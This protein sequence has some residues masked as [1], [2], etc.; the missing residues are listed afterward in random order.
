MRL[1]S[2]SYPVRSVAL[3]SKG[4]RR[5]DDHGR[6]VFAGP[7]GCPDI[8]GIKTQSRRPLPRTLRPIGCPDIKGIKTRA[9][10]TSPAKAVRS[11]ALISKGLRHIPDLL[12]GNANRPIGCPDIKGIKT[13][14]FRSCMT[15]PRP[16]GCPDIKGIKTHA[17]A[18]PSAQEGVR[19][20]ALI[21]KGLR[22]ALLSALTARSVRSVALISKG[23][24]PVRSLQ[25]S[26][27]RVRSVALI[28][29]G[30][31]PDASAGVAGVAGP[32][33]CPDIKGIKTWRGCLS[34]DGRRSDR[35]P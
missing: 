16:I 9:D 13:I 25:P 35:L 8:K 1:H 6:H 34:R 24:R 10:S 26:G 11:V 2:A 33:G 27:A 19:S 23:L 17:A 14:P 21:S 7:I 3:I 18:R 12:K 15:R 28:S 31:R 5:L 29:K 32:I 4:L 30:L 22:P 20:V